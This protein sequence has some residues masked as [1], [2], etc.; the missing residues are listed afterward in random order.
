MDCTGNARQPANECLNLTNLDFTG[1][2]RCADGWMVY[3]Q[4]G[5]DSDGEEE[6][7]AKPLRV[8]RSGRP[9]CNFGQGCGCRLKLDRVNSIN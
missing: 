5:R 6:V 8:I 1:S 3:Y 9:S 2:V 4:D 7:W